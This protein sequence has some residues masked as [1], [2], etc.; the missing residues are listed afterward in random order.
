MP[1]AASAARR[2]GTRAPVII[3]YTPAGVGLVRAPAEPP[4]DRD[5]EDLAPEF[6]AKVEA[7]FAWLRLRTWKPVA[8]ETIRTSERQTWLFNLG[9]TTALP[10]PDGR[11]L[12]GRVV[13]KART[14]R[15]SW[16]PY[17][18]AVD[19]V[20]AD[21]LWRETPRQ[22]RFRV[23][24]LAGAR[25]FGIRSGMDWD[26]DGASTDESFVDAPHLQDLRV[27]RSPTEQDMADFDAGRVH[28]VLQRY[29]VWAP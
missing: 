5:L 12:G 25:L 19:V 1:T 13:T 16:H 29:G 6:R 26:H 14:G 7:L 15:R 8:V 23:D 22:Q 2:P 10:K 17:R 21:E 20:D 9:R 11:G 27:P 24:L 28:R 18:V 4:A 3:S